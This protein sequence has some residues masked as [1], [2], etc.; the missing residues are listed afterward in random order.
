MT[1]KQ[2]VVLLIVVALG[3]WWFVRK[4]QTPSE[5][6]TNGRETK[7]EESKTA[8]S[9]SE[10]TEE[11]KSEKTKEEGVG[12]LSVGLTGSFTHKAY[13]YTV[14]FPSQWNWNGTQVHT[15]VLSSEKISANNEV[16]TKN[17]MKILRGDQP[18]PEDDVVVVELGSI[19]DESFRAVYLTD[20]NHLDIVA[21]IIASFK[22]KN[23]GILSL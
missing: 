15:F 9:K 1:Q 2:I 18:T 6:R 5:T 11:T 13:G 17:N 3:I 20:H 19:G 10:G 7:T 23:S 16:L 8:P 22:E 21:Q 12:A 4:E 14:Q